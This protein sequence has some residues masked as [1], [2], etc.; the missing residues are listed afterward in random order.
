MKK[1]L[2]ILALVVGAAGASV[3]AAYAC[4]CA[5]YDPISHSCISWICTPPPG[6][7]LVPSST[8]PGTDQILWCGKN[9]SGQQTCFI[10]PTSQALPNLAT[11][12]MDNMFYS[13]RTGPH[14][15]AW[16]WV[17]AGYL[18]TITSIPP[19]TWDTAPVATASSLQTAHE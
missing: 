13:V 12:G 17:N 15:H 10:G 8:V 3:A 1:L 7:T 2:L 11:Y 5:A 18:G 19:S 4:S 6:W 9:A 16:Y 14:A